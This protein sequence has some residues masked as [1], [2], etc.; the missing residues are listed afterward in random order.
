[1]S[2]GFSSFLCQRLRD[3]LKQ[4]FWVKLTTYVISIAVVSLNS[5]VNYQRIRDR[6]SL[7]LD[8][9]AQVVISN[10]HLAYRENT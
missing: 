2:G 8:Q 9:R 5:W 3:S 6:S 4:L 10:P 1:M 7:S